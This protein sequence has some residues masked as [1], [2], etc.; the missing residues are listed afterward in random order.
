MRSRAASRRVRR[1]TIAAVTIV[2][3]IRDFVRSPDAPPD[4]RDS[5]F[6]ELALAAFAY[7]FDRIERYRAHCERLGK[8]PATVASWRDVP[9][10]PAA[11]FASSRLATDP[12][13]ET[14]RSSGT[15]GPAGS[16]RSVHHHPFPEL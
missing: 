4:N 16:T 9:L 7:Q 13:I 15:M 3:E 5:R 8:T 2:G 14:F 12:P 11:A 1:E 10:V 6:E